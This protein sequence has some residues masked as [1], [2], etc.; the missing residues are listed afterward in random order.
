MNGNLMPAFF[1]KD[2]HH[3]PSLAIAYLNGDKSAGLEML[4]PDRTKLAI[5]RQ[6]IGIVSDQRQLRLMLSHLRWELGQ[7]R[8]RYVWWISQDSVDI[9]RQGVKPVLP[10]Q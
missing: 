1:A 8:P 7:F 10:N 9:L 2:L 4:L 6:P 5:E 3:L